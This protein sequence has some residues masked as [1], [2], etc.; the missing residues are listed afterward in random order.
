MYYKSL[1]NE[2][3]SLLGTLKSRRY[4]LKRGI[5]VKTADSTIF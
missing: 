2:I 5:P 3:I 1:I 4:R